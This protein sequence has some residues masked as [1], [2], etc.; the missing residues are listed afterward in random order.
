MRRVQS[1][2]DSENRAA[3][4]P[5]VRSHAERGNEKKRCFYETSL[6]DSLGR[7]LQRIEVDGT[8]SLDAFRIG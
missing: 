1:T 4:R 5:D 3:E 7:K 2:H 6:T 8:F